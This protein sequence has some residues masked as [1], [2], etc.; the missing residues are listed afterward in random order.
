MVRN[1]ACG[2]SN[3]QTSWFR[4]GHLMN[5]GTLSDAKVLLAKTI[6]LAKEVR[7]L[8][9]RARQPLSCNKH[10]RSAGDCQFVQLP[11]LH[12]P[13]GPNIKGLALSNM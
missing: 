12:G 6:D 4:R 10:T 13:G 3:I 9:Q 11:A 8:L 5:C 7:R 2:T 1:D